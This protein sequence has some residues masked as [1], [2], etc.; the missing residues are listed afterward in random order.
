MSLNEKKKRRS[1]AVS[2]IDA[3]QVVASQVPPDRRKEMLEYMQLFGYNPDRS[4]LQ[5]HIPGFF[6]K[7]RAS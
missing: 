1:Q 5:V 4:I 2:T 6:N 7:K 3:E